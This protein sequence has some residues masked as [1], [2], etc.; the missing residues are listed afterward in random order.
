MKLYL[1]KLNHVS[2]RRRND[3]RF[4]CDDEIVTFKR[5]NVLTGSNQKWLHVKSLLPAAKMTNS[6][7]KKQLLRPNLALS[8][9]VSESYLPLANFLIFQF[10][11]STVDSHTSCSPERKQ[12]LSLI[13]FPVPL[14]SLRMYL[15]HHTWLSCW[16][17]QVLSSEKMIL[18]RWALAG[19]C[20]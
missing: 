10:S 8:I 14:K 15:Y 13:F 1:I 12:N 11:R 7:F 20:I 4:L 5:N 17:Q 6:I 3:Y 18:F 16:L 2:D 9:W 19:D